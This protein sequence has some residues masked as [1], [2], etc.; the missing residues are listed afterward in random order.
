MFFRTKSDLDSLAG[1]VK[2]EFLKDTSF[3]DKGDTVAGD[4]D[5]AE[6]MGVEKDGGAGER[7]D[8]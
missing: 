8:R 5:F 6:E 2:G 4:F 7:G 3:F 1:F